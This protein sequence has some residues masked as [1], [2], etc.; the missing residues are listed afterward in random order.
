M[1]QRISFQRVVCLALLVMTISLIPVAIA[2][3]TESSVLLPQAEQGVLASTYENGR[4]KTPDDGTTQ[5]ADRGQI[6]DDGMEATETIESLRHDLDRLSEEFTQAA[7]RSSPFGFNIEII[8][9]A[10]A[11][12]VSV[13][14]ILL[15]CFLFR[16]LHKDFKRLTKL[17]HHFEQQIRSEFVGMETKQ[18]FLIAQLK[19]DVQSVDQ[20]QA[21]S[22]ATP[23]LKSLSSSLAPAFCSSVTSLDE[24]N[25]VLSSSTSQSI[26]GLIRAINTG[27]NK[28]LSK[29]KRT[30]LNI[31][32]YSK[33]T[34][35][36]GMSEET[37]LEEVA[38]NGNYMMVTIDKTQLLF[39]SKHMLNQFSTTQPSE[40]LF[41]YEQRSVTKA[42][43]IEPAVLEKSGA[44]WRV[45]QKGKVAIP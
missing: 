6:N 11:L 19:S 20:K 5:G 13:V 8:I 42:E 18:Q 10:A 35:A 43:I 2:R 25:N 27:D 22:D 44:V 12:L 21:P 29:A 7:Q 34:I 45:S 24:L 16:S 40:G 30:Q 3:T 37:E 15:S 39:P 14:S 36:M 31:S 9:A 28:V 4:G 38:F 26:A 17:L 23:A 41:D 1:M 33:N 32:N